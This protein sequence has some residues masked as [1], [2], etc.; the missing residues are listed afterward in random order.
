MTPEKNRGEKATPES[1]KGPRVRRPL[2]VLRGE[3]TR[4]IADVE[5]GENPIIWGD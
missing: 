3:N 4:V 1:K 5:S 2:T